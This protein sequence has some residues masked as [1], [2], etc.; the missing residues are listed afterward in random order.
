MDVFALYNALD[1]VEGT[2]SMSTIT[3]LSTNVEIDEYRSW[4]KSVAQAK[5]VI[6]QY[7][8]DELH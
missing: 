4:K 3:D 8:S 1:I 7:I 2:R 6:S 5:I